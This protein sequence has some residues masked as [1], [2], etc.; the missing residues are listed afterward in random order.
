MLKVII[1]I[2]IGVAWA[3]FGAYM[4]KKPKNT[5]VH[6]RSDYSSDGKKKSN[7]NNDFA[8]SSYDASA[9]DSNDQDVV[10]ESIDED[11][12]NANVVAKDE[13][14]DASKDESN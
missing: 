4:A 11:N 3:V 13:S 2:L 1:E 8:D 9:D 7:Q 14:K 6:K 5:K 10:I 12:S